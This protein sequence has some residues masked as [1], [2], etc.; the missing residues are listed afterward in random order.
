[1]RVETGDNVLIAGFIVIGSGQKS[2]AVRALGPSLPIAGALG[3]PILEL[4]DASG[5]IVASNDDWQSSQQTALIA[6]G[7]APGNDRDAALIATLNAGSY[8]AVVRGVS[9]TA[10]VAL[11]E[12][13][14]LDGDQAPARLANISTRGKVET[15]DNVM[16]G[17]FILR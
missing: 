14:D 12:V 4:H 7:L 1:M 16:I 6:A 5:A 17:G 10:G 9:S 11:V 3:N 8:T 13:Y 2:V 15:G